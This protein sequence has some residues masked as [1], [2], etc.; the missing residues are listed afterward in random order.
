MVN[1]L[2]DYANANVVNFLSDL[3]VDGGPAPE[4][5][6][7]I[8]VERASLLLRRICHDDPPTYYE[9][10][11]D[12]ASSLADHPE[13]YQADT[14]VIYP[15][16]PTDPNW[17]LAMVKTLDGQPDTVWLFEPGKHRKLT[18]DAF[19]TASETCDL[20]IKV[21]V[22]RFLPC[23]KLSE[24]GAA[25]V[26]CALTAEQLDWPDTETFKHP[27]SGRMDHSWTITLNLIVEAMDNNYKPV[28]NF[29]RSLQ[30]DKLDWHA[31]WERTLEEILGDEAGDHSG[32]A[33]TRG[34]AM[35]DD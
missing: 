21:A 26:L 8:S 31:T 34:S 35:H 4:L 24:R 10:A 11:R 22:C 3:L 23:H 14:L 27:F 12:F 13:D 19:N 1:Q 2:Q 15:I 28:L 30:P 18:L 32:S 33:E 29:L 9:S 16:T 20:D 6:D 5:Y 25:Q 7:P 17:S